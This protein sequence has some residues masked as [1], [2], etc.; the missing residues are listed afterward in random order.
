MYLTDNVSKPT[1]WQITKGDTRARTTIPPHGYLVIWCDNKR[2]TTDGGLHA[3]F[4]IDGDGGQV[5][6]MA[7]DRSWGDVL[8]YGAHDAA[9]TVGRFPD[10]SADVYA[11]NVATIGT[12]NIMTS[13]MTPVDQQHIDVSVRPISAANGLRICYGA[14]QLLVKSDDAQR[15][16]V[17]IYRTDGI[18]ADQASLD[19]SGHSARLSVESLQPGLYIA[20]ATG[21]D[22]TTVSCKFMK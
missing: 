7:A 3:T 13:Y 21:T 6:I 22:G 5:A 11:T 8:T 9:T 20:R 18:L 16:S 12:S 10:G 17:S 14:Q 15:V 4:K 2:A 1:K 19:V